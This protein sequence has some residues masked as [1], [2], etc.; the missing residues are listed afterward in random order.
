MS[1]TILDLGCGNRKT[2]GAIGVDSNPRTQ[3]DVIHSLETFPYP[4]SDSS[5]DEIVMDNSLEHLDDPIR[6]LEE[7]HRIG[8]PGALIRIYV[9]YF[10]AHWAYND[11]T[12]KR[13]YS[14]EA[15]A[16]FDPAHA[17]NKLYP[18]SKATFTVE[19]IL[20]NERI[21]RGPLYSLVKAVANRWPTRYETHLSHFFPL[22]ELT[23]HLRV[24]K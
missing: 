2:P 9:P 13:F 19:R 5:V 16:H 22:D 12:H 11:P 15:F 23:F 20:F 8:K 17:Y 18:Y 14:A 24:L 4:F 1:P 7:L 10:R 3:A 21:K 6:V